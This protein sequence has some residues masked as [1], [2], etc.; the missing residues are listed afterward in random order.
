V[1]TITALTVKNKQLIIAS[2]EQLE[3]HCCIN[4]TLKHGNNR[5][6]HLTVIHDCLVYPQ[7]T[8]TIFAQWLSYSATINVSSISHNCWQLHP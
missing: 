3:K 4:I 6:K 5:P 1:E 8:T 7:K 2:P